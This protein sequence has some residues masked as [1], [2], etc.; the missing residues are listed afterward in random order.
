MTVSVH[1]RETSRMDY[2]FK[3]EDPGPWKCCCA[4]V[5]LRAQPKFAIFLLGTARETHT[6]TTG[7]DIAGEA[8]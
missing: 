1:L 2:S 5:V 4:C 8:V 6:E 3:D 7:D